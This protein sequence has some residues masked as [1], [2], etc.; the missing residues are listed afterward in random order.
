[1]AS[2]GIYHIINFYEHSA[3][4]ESSGMALQMSERLNKDVISLSFYNRSKSAVCAGGV[5]LML[6]CVLLYTRT[7]RGCLEL[8]YV[9]IKVKPIIIKPLK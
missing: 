7:H 8:F 9:L 1:M 3:V 4:I 6:V 5:S 2:D